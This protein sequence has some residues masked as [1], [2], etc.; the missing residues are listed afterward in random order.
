MALLDCCMRRSSFG[1]IHAINRGALPA[2]PSQYVDVS[3]KQLSRHLSRHG[4][5]RLGCKK[6]PPRNN[7]HL[8]IVAM[9]SLAAFEN[10]DIGEVTN[11]VI[12]EYIWLAILSQVV[13]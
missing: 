3:T 13:V 7:S 11:E 12:A 9:S 6:Q 4:Q 2:L 5:P 1:G 8:Q 10:L